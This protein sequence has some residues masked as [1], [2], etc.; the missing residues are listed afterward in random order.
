[1]TDASSQHAP[2]PDHDVCERARL[3]RDARFDGLFYTAVTS[4]GIYC[5]PVCPAPPPK[6][7]HVRYYGSA[8]Q[9][10]A[11]GFRP[12][13]R[14]RP[15]RAPH[16]HHQ[17]EDTRLAQAARLV[18]DGFLN[19]HSNAALAETCQLSSRQLSR[20]FLA[21][22]GTTPQQLH[23]TQ[24]LLFAKK[25]LSET[26]LPITQVALAAG[27]QSL[28][29]F[30]DVFQK[31]YQLTPSSI[32]KEGTRKASGDGLT[33]TLNHRPP[34]DFSAS[35]TW[36]QQRALPGIE[37]VEGGQYRRL[38][39]VNDDESPAWLQ[40]SVHPKQAN[41][42]SLT[43]FGVPHKQIKSM[44]TRLRRMFDLDANPEAIHACL[45]QDKRLNTAIRTQP[46]LRIPGAWDGF[47]TAIRAIIGQQVSVA[48]AYTLTKRFVD[49]LGQAVPQPP[50]ADLHRLFPTPR[51]VVEADM[52]GLG[53][54]QRRIDSIRAVAQA[55]LEGRVD[56]NPHQP[57]DEWVKQWV[58]LPGIGDWTA[59][60]IALRALCHPDAF[61]AGDLVLRKALVET[62]GSLPSIKQVTQ[63]AEAWRPWRGYAA[64]HLWSL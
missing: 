21:Q 31:A 32:R 28:R 24:R 57:L 41:T 2:I 54:T 52:S 46:G 19:E 50:H 5:R 37:S 8:A 22:Y 29:R 9:C 40:L 36:L 48:A 47:E 27:F 20:L 33:L 49:R 30:N 59:Q 6:P 61:P 13:L 15:E 18:A 38:I 42:L 14:C 44:L 51:M 3:S 55:L 17:V 53:I 26:H 12:C 23:Q 64:L 34:F 39:A 4:T 63:T 25:L 62:D 16:T 60:Y 56:F 10:E 43:L 35:L 7:V 11:A 58:A 1:M 45:A